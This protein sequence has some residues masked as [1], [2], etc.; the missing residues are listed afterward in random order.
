MLYPTI[1]QVNV[2]NVMKTFKTNAANATA[3]ILKAIPQIV[4]EDWTA[5]LQENKVINNYMMK[6]A[7]CI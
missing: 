3:I 5:T 2:E 4:K 1:I 7:N 6:I